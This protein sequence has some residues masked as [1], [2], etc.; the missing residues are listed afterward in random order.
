MDDNLKYLTLI[1]ILKVQ[2]HS[3]MVFKGER[4]PVFHQVFPALPALP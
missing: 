4:G 2:L 1:V 3:I